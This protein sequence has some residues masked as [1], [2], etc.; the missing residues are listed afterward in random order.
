MKVAILSRP[1]PTHSLHTYQSNLKDHLARMGVEFE[2]FYNSPPPAADI[3][4]DPGLG[5]GPVPQCLRR[6]ESPVVAT[7]HGLYAFS[8]PPSLWPSRL[9]ILLTKL[10]VLK[11][12]N[13]FRKRV[14]TVIAV[15]EYGA[16]EIR[17]AV[18][19]RNVV[20]IHHGVDHNIFR[21]PEDPHRGSHLLV[22]ISNPELALKK[23][24]PRVLRAYIRLPSSSP[25][26]VLLAP[27][28][29][30]DPP[31]EYGLPQT[32]LVRKISI[33]R[34]YVTTGKLVSLYQN[35]LALVHPSLHE[36]FGLPIVEAMACGCPVITSRGTACGEVAGNAALLVDPYSVDDISA[37][38][39][40]VLDPAYRKS[41]VELGLKRASQFDWRKS[42]EQHLRV[43]EEA[44]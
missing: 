13:W 4:W 29:G 11:D 32:S 43:M 14:S 31:V 6:G 33:I 27:G 1:I 16:E 9:P 7:C 2:P 30:G 20:P 22:T 37:A 35:A 36:N 8:V 23:N 18:G 21:P 44:M 19:V 39:E 38:M 40:R 17:R 34:Q 10:R 3:V 41:M 42:A 26:L 25:P 12:W 15:S 24:L 28:Y 5:M